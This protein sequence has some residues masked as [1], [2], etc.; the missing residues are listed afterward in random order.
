[1]KPVTSP[2]EWL[3]FPRIKT[4]TDTATSVPVSIHAASW[5]PAP[6]PAAG[7]LHPDPFAVGPDKRVAVSGSVA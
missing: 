3:S 4:E 6:P 7:P 5:A 2:V 1:M